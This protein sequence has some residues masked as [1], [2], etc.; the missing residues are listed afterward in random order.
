MIKLLL[1]I[2][3][4]RRI[5]LH[6]KAYLWELIFLGLFG[7]TAATYSAILAIFGANSM[8]KPCYWK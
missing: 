5:P 4:F 3:V 8:T 2:V 6:V 7:G 1:I